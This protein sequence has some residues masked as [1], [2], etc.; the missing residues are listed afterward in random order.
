MKLTTLFI[1][2]LMLLTSVTGSTVELGILQADKSRITFISKQMGVPIEGKFGQFNA[3][4]AFDPAHPETAKAHVEIAM[5]SIDA[6]NPDSN[7]EIRL[8]G[9]FNTDKFKT[10]VFEADSFKLSSDGSYEAMGKMTIKG[11]TQPVKVIFSATQTDTVATIDGNLLIS[12]KQFGIGTA[13][14]AEI[15]G[16]EVKLLF[17][18][19]FIPSQK[20]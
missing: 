1:T 14:W 5:E 7:E 15:V 12:R 11:I 16:D 6:G 18:F 3:K 2:M 20:S 13:E 9:W 17:H 10:A 4:I 19:N 8:S